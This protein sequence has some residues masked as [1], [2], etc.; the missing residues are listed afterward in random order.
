MRPSRAFAKPVRSIFPITRWRQPSLSP[1]A[2]DEV[3]LTAVALRASKRSQVL[4]PHARL[5]H[6][7]SHRRIASHASRTLVLF[8][9]HTLP[10]CWAEARHSLSPIDGDTGR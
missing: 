5:N 3:Q 1:G 7:Q 10:L 4:A 9:E 8:V 2:F 6:R